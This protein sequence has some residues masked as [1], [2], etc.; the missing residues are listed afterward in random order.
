MKNDPKNLLE[1]YVQLM[2]KALEMLKRD[3]ELA[4]SAEG[5][6]VLENLKKSLRETLNRFCENMDAE[7]AEGKITDEAILKQYKELRDKIANL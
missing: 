3:P 2:E 6:T 4:Q 1:N 5:L 7:M